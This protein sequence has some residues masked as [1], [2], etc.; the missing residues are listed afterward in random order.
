MNPGIIAADDS[1]LCL[2]ELKEIF[3][4]LA[5]DIRMAATMEDCIELCRESRP[6]AV[7]VYA[8]MA[9]AFSLLRLLRRSEDLA[10][11]PLVVV[12]DPEQEELIAK[13]RTL[14]SRADRYMLRPLDRELAR[15]VL[16][17]FFE[18][19]PLD[20]EILLTI[21]EKTP[22]PLPI[23]PPDYLHDAPDAATRMEEELHRYQGRVKEL[24]Q[25]LKD[26]MRVAKENAELRREID[27]L[28]GQMAEARS[29][30]TGG[31]DFGELFG[32]LEI[33]Y[34]DTI[35]DL[36]K[37]LQE[38]DELIANLASGDAGSGHESEALAQELEREHAR[39]GELVGTLRRLSTL[40][41][42]WAGEEEG[43]AV[44][45]LLELLAKQDEAEGLH[46]GLSFDEETVVVDADIIKRHL[47]E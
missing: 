9:R 43:L 30:S 12:G 37:L 25:D 6:D 29:E 44:Q 27:Q 16:E 3:G 33:G 5:V 42:N 38:K 15:G 45:E 36:E 31:Q 14:P 2:S 11:I 20:G 47:Q 41:Q 4:P 39:H 10:S 17:E 24:E 7:V 13:H 18:D 26:A 35:A 1:G 40:L 19:E 34:K 32:R 21:P 22:P 28:Q 8:G 23:D 46:G